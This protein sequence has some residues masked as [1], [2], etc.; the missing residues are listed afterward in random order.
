MK[1]LL[2]LAILFSFTSY[3]AESKGP[4]EKMPICVRPTDFS[5]GKFVASYEA[6]MKRQETFCEIHK[7]NKECLAIPQTGKPYYKTTTD[8][9]D[10][11]KRC[12]IEKDDSYKCLQDPIRIVVAEEAK[13]IPSVS[14]TPSG[15]P[16]PEEGAGTGTGTGDEKS[17][18]VVPPPPPPHPH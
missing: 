17:P 14:T 11:S 18:P 4:V 13:T 16:I 6:C 7:E 9:I 15:S 5:N 8:N 2:I 1:N 10:P 12:K 3:G